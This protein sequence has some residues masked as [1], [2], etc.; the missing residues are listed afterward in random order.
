ME[1]Y[2]KPYCRPGESDPQRMLGFVI[3]CELFWV[4]VIL[5]SAAYLAS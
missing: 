3:L 4:L 2:R 5:V 1:P